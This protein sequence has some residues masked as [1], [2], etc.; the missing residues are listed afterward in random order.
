M[1]LGSKK[2]AITIARLCLDKKAKDTIVLDM[3]GLTSFTDYFVICSGETTTQ[4]RA[5][6]EYVEESLRKIGR[7]LK[8]LSIEGF[9]FS[10]WVLMDYSDVILHIFEEDTRQ[11]YKLENLWLDA[12]RIPV[13][14]GN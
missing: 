9:R 7:K 4:I 10:H 11:Y 6:A 5:I 12:P 2:K 8:P 3:K 13:E 14:E 1:G